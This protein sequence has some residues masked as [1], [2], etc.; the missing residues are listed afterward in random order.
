[1]INFAPPSIN[2]QY[3]YAMAYTVKKFMWTLPYHKQSSPRVSSIFYSLSL[4]N[5]D[6]NGDRCR[7]TYTQF[8]TFCL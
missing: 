5:G 2:S 1:M 3:A 4:P 8:W 6:G 7:Y